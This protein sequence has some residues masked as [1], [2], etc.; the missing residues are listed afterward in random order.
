MIVVFFIIHLKGICLAPWGFGGWRRDFVLVAIEGTD[1]FVAGF[2]NVNEK[3]RPL[4]LCLAPGGF[5]G[6][7]G[8]MVKATL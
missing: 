5:G 7:L 4:R 2:G 3:N 1:G 6:W 8:M